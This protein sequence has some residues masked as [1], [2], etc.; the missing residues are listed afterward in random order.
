[1]WNKNKKRN[2]KLIE[3][4]WLPGTRSWGKWVDVGQRLQIFIDEMS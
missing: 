2:V 1:M 4:C 3:E